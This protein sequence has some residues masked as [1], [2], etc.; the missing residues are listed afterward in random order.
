[1]YKNISAQELKSLMDKENITLVDIRETFEYQM[2]HVKNAQNIP[3]NELAY[4]H[5]K[6][7]NK[8][9]TYYIICQSGGRSSSMC[10]YLGSQG[11]QVIN[12]A[13]GTGMWPF[14]LDY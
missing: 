2:G 6:Y 10:Q 14:G 3:M 5:T 4:N 8:N 12:V 7:L 13:G 1:M 11:Y 9:E